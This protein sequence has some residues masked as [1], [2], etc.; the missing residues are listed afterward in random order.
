MRGRTVHLYTFELDELDN[1]HGFLRGRQHDT[2]AAD[3]GERFHLRFHRRNGG[4]QH[5]AVPNAES[6]AEPYA[7]RTVLMTVGGR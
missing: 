1:L 6:D 2:R 5:G 7:N 3:L 4:V